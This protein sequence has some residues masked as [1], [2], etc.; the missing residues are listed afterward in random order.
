M[1]SQLKGIVYIIPRLFDGKSEMALL[2]NHLSILRIATS[3]PAKT[4]KCVHD[5]SP[6]L[7]NRGKSVLDVIPLHFYTSNADTSF[8]LV[9]NLHTRLS[10]TYLIWM[11]YKS[12]KYARSWCTLYV[13]CSLSLRIGRIFTCWR[14]FTP[15]LKIAPYESDSNNNV[16]G[17]RKRNVLKETRHFFYF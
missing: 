3:L 4:Y 16:S 10:Q 13:C 9:F 7:C 17:P 5:V 12:D 14:F 11:F 2:K 1:K 6:H 8:Q 15:T